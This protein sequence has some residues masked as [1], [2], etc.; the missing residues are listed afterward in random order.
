MHRIER[1]YDLKLRAVAKAHA[2][3]LN[4]EPDIEARAIKRRLRVRTTHERHRNLAR[5]YGE[6]KK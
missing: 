2:Q 1:T 5:H 4:L 6:G 3:R